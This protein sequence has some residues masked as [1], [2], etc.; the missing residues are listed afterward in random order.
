[1]TLVFVALGSNIAPEQHLRQA[2]QAI[3]A[4]STLLAV[5]RVYETEPLG[6]RAQPRF[7][8]A[9]VL[10]ET[11]LAPA[12]LKELLQTIEARLGRVR[13]ADRNA[14]RTIDLDITL[15]GDQRLSL[16]GREIPEPDLLAHAHLAVPLAELSPAHRHPVNRRTLR[17]IARSCH[18]GGLVLR[19][20]IVLWPS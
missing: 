19:R 9:A 12:E 15:F 10:I 11:E 4:A 2:V 7:L 20:D 14:P 3:A 8:N 13:R 6:N 5:S 16:A 17:E 1:M 18:A